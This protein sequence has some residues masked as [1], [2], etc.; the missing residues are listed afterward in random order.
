MTLARMLFGCSLGSTKG[1]ANDLVVLRH[2]GEVQRRSKVRAH[3]QRFGH[4][5]AAVGAI[6]EEDA[7]VILADQADRVVARV[8][9]GHRLDELVGDAAL[10]GPLDGGH[11]IGGLFARAGD[12]GELGALDPFPALVAIHRVVAAGDGG[13]AAHADAPHLALQ[14]FDESRSAFGRRIAAVHEAVDADVA[15]LLA[16]GHFEQ[17]VEVRVHGMHAAVAEQTHQVKT[18]APA[19]GTGVMHRGQQRGIAEEIARRRS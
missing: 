3:G 6:V 17:R 5:A 7:R 10:I 12:H 13:D 9:D 14:G 16:L 2:G 19:L 11:R 1:T 15:H 4:L 18:P 8:D